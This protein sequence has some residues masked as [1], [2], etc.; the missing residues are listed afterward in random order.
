M[1]RLNKLSKILTEQGTERLL[2]QTNQRYY[3]QC[4]DYLCMCLT[5]M[6]GLEHIDLMSG[7]LMVREGKGAK[8]RRDGVFA[9][10]LERHAGGDLSPS[11][12]S[13]AV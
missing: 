13:Q 10:H 4:Q 2:Q 8:D 3:G 9:T 11:P 12:L 6:A 5:L 7:K 1:T